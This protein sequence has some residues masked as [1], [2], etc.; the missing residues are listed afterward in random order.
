MLVSGH[1]QALS[2]GQLPEVD[3]VP[4]ERSF[5][6]GCLANSWTDIQKNRATGVV[7]YLLVF[8]FKIK[9]EGGIRPFEEMTVMILMGRCYYVALMV[10]K[11]FWEVSRAGVCKP[12]PGGP[13]S[14]E[15]SS[16]LPFASI[17]LSGS[18]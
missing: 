15:F 2:P 1:F 17:H 16:N 7:H 12:A 10:G 4:G 5:G 11:M 13:V 6:T 18:F 14:K 3:S 9:F 8:D